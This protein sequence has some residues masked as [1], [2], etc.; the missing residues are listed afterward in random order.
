MRE[1]KRGEIY[2]ADLNPIVG[3]E[4]RG[5]RPVVILQNDIGNHFADTTIVAAITSR[6]RSCDLPIH[7]KIDK[8]GQMHRDSTVLL[9]QLR[10]VD[11]ARLGACLGQLEDHDLRQVE[12]ALR[13][14][15]EL[16]G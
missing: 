9:E 12:K 15:L 16:G 14:S 4:Q 7:A 10:T 13:I 2:I 5:T 3:S 6:V 11:K 8:T 1:I